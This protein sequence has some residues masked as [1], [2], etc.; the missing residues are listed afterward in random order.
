M[1]N[2]NLFTISVVVLCS[3]Y[4]ESYIWAYNTFII[5]VYEYN[6]LEMQLRTGVRDFYLCINPSFAVSYRTVLEIYAIYF[7]YDNARRLLCLNCLY[8]MINVNACITS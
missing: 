7:I 3:F 1:Y 5:Y 8:C 2:E 6:N 4:A